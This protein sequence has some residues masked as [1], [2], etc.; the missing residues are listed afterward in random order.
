MSGWTQ[1]HHPL[2]GPAL[3]RRTATGRRGTGTRGRSAD[4]DGRAVLGR[5]RWFATRRQILRLQAELHKTIVFVTRHR[6]ALKLAD[7]VAVFAPGG[8]R[9]T[10]KLPRLLSVR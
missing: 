6:Q 5:R 1:G 9:S 2:P 7:L 10:T 8:A 3:G 4:L